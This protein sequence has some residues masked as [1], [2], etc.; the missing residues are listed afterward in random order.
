MAKTLYELYLDNMKKAGTQKASQPAALPAIKMPTLEAPKTTPAAGSATGVKMPTV[1]AKKPSGVDI[2]KAVTQ[3]PAAQGGGRATMPQVKKQETATDRLANIRAFGAGDYSGGG[4]LLE[5]AY[6]TARGAVKG[7]GSAYANIGGSAV[8]GMGNLQETMQKGEY[9]RKIQQMKDNKAF[10]EQALKSGINPRTGKR[11]TV[12]EKSRYYK[13]LNTQYTDSKISQMENI[14]KDAT[15]SQKARTM[16]AANDAFAASDRLKASADKDVAAAKEGSG[17]VGQF[18]V[19]LGYTGTQLL[20]D[21]AA[22]AIAPGAGMVSMASRVYGDASAEARREGKTAGQQV[23][24]GLKGA[25]IEVLTEKL[26][27]GLAKAY[28][29]GTADALVE[30]MADKLTR[31]D[32]GKRVATWLIN[33]GGE[34]IEEVVSD[35]LNP[36]ADRALGLDDG[37]SPIYTTDDVAQMGYDFL[38]GTAMGA[39]GGAG[40]LRDTKSSAPA[41]QETRPV[42][43]P[44]LVDANGRTAAQRQAWAQLSEPQR[45]QLDEADKIARRFGARVELDS[46]EGVSGSYRDGAITLNPNTANPVRQTLIRELT[47]HME[48]SGL[49]SRF[50]DTAMRYVAENM[51]ADVESVR[52]AVMADYARS[53]V[54]LDEDGATREIVAKFAEEKLFTDEATV[55]RLLAEDRNLFQRI[56]DWIRDALN[57]LSGTGEEAYLR[58][59]EKLYAKAL[60]ET[61]AQESERGAQMLFAGKNAKTA[62]MRTLE[63]A[64][65]LEADG[66]SPESILKETGWFRGMDGKWRFEIDDSGMEYRR[67]GDARLLEESGY[68]RLQELTDKWARNAE[69]RGDPLTAEEQ[70]ESENLAGKYYDS[71]WTEEKYELADFLRHS[72]LFEAYPQLRHTSL[73]FEKTEPGVNGYYNA[74][75]DTIVL[76]DKLRWIPESTLVHE[77]QHVIQRAEGFARGSS[78]EYWARRDY[79]TGDITRSLEREYDRIL[80]ELD[81]EMR[82][83]YLRYQEVNRAMENLENAEDGTPAA[84]KYIQLEKV[85]DQLYTELWG[86]P[87]FNRLL[88]LKRQIDTPREVY[89]RFY[90]N[91]AG[92]IEAPDAAA[93]RDYS[94][95][96]RRRRMPQLGDANTV[97]ADGNT[98]AYDINPNHRNAVEQW[99][100]EGRPEGEMFILGSTGSVLQGLGAIESDIYMQ[101]DKINRILQ[102]HPEMTLE[103]IK[104]LP[105]ILEDPVLVLKSKGSGGIGKTSRVVMFGTV[106]AQNGQ[107]VMAVLDLRPYENGFLVTDMQKVNSSYTKK[108]PA[109]FI[110]SSEVLYADK[111]RAA[112]LLRLTGLTIASQQ[113]LQNGSV[114]SISYAGQDVNIEGTPFSDM[115]RREQL[116]AGRGLEEMQRDGVQMPVVDNQAAEPMQSAAWITPAEETSTPEKNYPSFDGQL[117]L[118]QVVRAEIEAEMAQWTAEDQAEAPTLTAEEIEA[119]Q[120]DAEAIGRATAMM[121]R[122]FAEMEQQA[123]EQRRQQE[124]AGRQI[125][126]TLRRLGVDPYGSEA[127]YAGAETLAREAKNSNS[128]RR[129]IQK[130]IGKMEASEKERLF[131]RQLAEGKLTLRDIPGTLDAERLLNLADLYR[132]M[133]SDPAAALLGRRRETILNRET[134]KMEPLLGMDVTYDEGGMTDTGKRSGSVAKRFGTLRRNLQTPARVCETEWGAAHGREVYDALFRPV[135]E[136]NGRQITWVNSML[137][138]VRTFK[139]SSGNV[140]ELNR[141][142]RALVQRL[143]EHQAAEGRVMKIGAQYSNAVAEM[144]KVRK[145]HAE[146]KGVTVEEYL[147]KNG[148]IQAEKESELRR[149]ALEYWRKTKAGEL[150]GISRD[151]YISSSYPDLAEYEGGKLEG[152]KELYEK[153]MA[154]E[155]KSQSAMKIIQEAIGGGERARKYLNWLGV[156]WR[157]YEK[158]YLNPEAI[159]KRNTE[160]KNARDAYKKAKRGMDSAKAT[161]PFLCAA[162]NVRNGQA[163]EDAAREFGID[164]STQ[165]YEDLLNYQA[166]IS[167][168]EDLKNSKEADATAVQAA[169][170]TYSGIYKELYEGINTFLVAHGYQPIGF[171]EGY[172]PHLQPEAEKKAFTKALKLLG[173]D[174]VAMELPT[175]I[176]GKTAELKPYKQ[177]N[178]FF[179]K[180]RGDKTEYDIAK[181]YEDYVYYLGNIFYHTDDIMRIRAAERYIRKT[182]SSEEASEMISQAE[183]ARNFSDA[184]IE[185]FLRM[186]GVVGKDTQLGEGDARNLLG[187]YIGKLYDQVG[188]VTRYSEMA[189]YLDNYA[190]RLAGKQSY[191]DRGAEAATGRG[192]LNWINALSGKYGGAKLAFNFSSAINQ[193]SQLPMVAVENGEINTARAMRDFFGKDRANFVKESNFLNGKR[194]VKWLLGAETGWDKFKQYG[195]TMT[196]AVDSFTAYTAVRSK[197][198]KEVKAGKSHAEA[199]ALADEYGRRVMGSRARGEK[200]VLFDTKNP[201]WQIVTRFQLETMNSW[202][203]VRRDLPNEYRTMASEKG[204]AYAA[205]VM[206]G[207]AARYVLYAFLANLGVGMLSGGS[208]VPYDVVGNTVE[209]LG[210]AWG[211]T[212]STAVATILD[213]VLQA[214]FDER[215]FG[216]PEPDDEDNA[217]WWAALESLFGNAANDI[218]VVSRTA[219]LAGIGD[220]TLAAADLSKAWDVVKDVKN[221]GFSTDTLDKALTAS[222]EFLYGGNQLR[223]TVQGTMDVAR[224]GRYSKGKLRYQVEQ[225]PCNFIKGALF[226]RSSL[227]EAQDYYAE[228]SSDFSARQTEAF[229]SM[230]DAGVTAKESYDL[231][232]KLRGI[233]KTDDESRAELQR[234]ALMAST[235]SGEGKAAAYYGLLASDTEKDAMDAVDAAD[236][237]TDMGEVTRL[238]VQFKGCKNDAQK[239]ESLESSTLTLKQKAEMYNNLIA[240]EETLRKQSDLE[241]F[242][243]ITAEGYYLY[244]AAT[245]GLTVKAAKLLA[246]DSLNLTAAQKDALYYSE[247]WAESKLHEAPWHGGQ[248]AA[249]RMPVV[250]TTGGAPVFVRVTQS[251]PTVQMPV[252][253]TTAKAPVFVRV[254]QNAPKAVRVVKMP[255]VK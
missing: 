194:G 249:V 40:Q 32:A 136:N 107:P 128:A 72:G 13:I 185:E 207:R 54:T 237:D 190:N 86:T 123:R 71:V 29:T 11:L 81:S 120:E 242:N 15:V 202:E 60:R 165:E 224:G 146:A 20:A 182:Y 5:K 137:D 21:T 162:E 157:E 225:T 192:S 14:Y 113:L 139:D 140:R 135:T 168:M 45:A 43:M 176:S 67:D 156:N 24:S 147:R 42:Q 245:L 106:R 74:G 7:I 47:H 188:N 179:Q 158:A 234:R 170:Q 52:Q 53:G 66:T 214:V 208:P 63:R 2:V 33:S 19:D 142:E 217:D 64:V 232:Q 153:V 112:P 75:T 209:A 253:R 27:G 116:S 213:N 17:K 199:L 251:V 28:G 109:D 206:G 73:V 12:D 95:E 23:L 183:A 70:A 90:R 195:F 221:N 39:I 169:V 100:R 49:Y 118:P 76:S 154:G 98:A 246:I 1:G 48:S 87:E 227:D 37:K 36:L 226:G 91:T 16:E 243:G 4:Q 99:N 26:F 210:K 131:A 55:R 212:K 58:N 77:I 236:P 173:L 196:E 82:N 121:D 211:L 130:Q 215:L 111:K 231:I 8:E 105:E 150:D 200:P 148:F 175:S 62:D 125:P 102:D 222:G 160:V 138:K 88:D 235:V 31:T 159:F 180:R 69:G 38:L 127:D 61:G 145:A 184:G 101:G 92:E 94:A 201:F 124:E 104:R 193:T 65:A 117:K 68:R 119:S 144:Y 233:E 149:A 141:A 46:R 204:K 57:K 244:K 254:T 164:R 93:R 35:L 161:N 197:Y 78:P 80:G 110:R 134:A 171:I 41:A 223:K 6:K 167:A 163:A 10:Y 241:A 203:H 250:K 85:S 238:L 44:T 216:T 132:A 152:R 3:K 219:A 220:Q 143:V 205:G 59:A 129:S 181:G 25:T 97:F 30:K 252:V 166:Y 22:N 172:A 84:E 240:S 239:L 79:E 126:E 115:T 50:S 108:N 218:P 9:D 255:V 191:V 114:G 18:L 51:G 186:S 248:T 230:Q 155:V 83:R 228:K 56:Y 198:L 189:K 178:P 89:D 177:Y 247:G 122:D 229:G 96:Q 174:D 133:D 103:E 187:D 151:A 34:G